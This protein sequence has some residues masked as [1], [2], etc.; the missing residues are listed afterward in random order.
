MAERLTDAE[1]EEI[2][3]LIESGFSIRQT[4]RHVSR[5]PTTVFAVAHA[6]LLD[7]GRLARE[8]TRRQLMMA[9]ERAAAA[10]VSAPSP[11]D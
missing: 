2:V 7:V 5:S 4:A 1:R 6:A 11:P 3:V 10:G 8:R 9:A